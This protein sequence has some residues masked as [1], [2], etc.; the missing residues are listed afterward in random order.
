MHKRSRHEALLHKA[1]T[2]VRQ[3]SAKVVDT[4]RLHYHFSPQAYW[5]ND[6]NGLVYYDGWYHVFYQHHPYSPDWGS[7][8]WG[9]ARTRDFINW[10]HLPIALAPSEPYD[11]D[12]C[13]SGSAAAADGMLQLFFTG[14]RVVAGKV[15]RSVPCVQLRWNSL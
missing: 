13:F 5:M 9:H 10:E 15:I 14:H 1:D 12:G 6:P 3:G 2:S 8:H 4:Y 11:A 7:M